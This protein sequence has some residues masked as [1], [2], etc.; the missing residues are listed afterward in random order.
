MAMSAKRFLVGLMLLVA[1]SINAFAATTVIVKIKNNGNIN[2]IAASLGGTILDSMDD[3]A[4]YLLSVPSMP[5]T[6]PPGCASI[7]ANTA[8]VLPRFKG[9]VF[10]ASNNV[11]T[12][13]WYASQPAFRLIHAASAQA[14]STGRGVI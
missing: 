4:T 2:S 8:L 13:P 10:T 12:L 1:L 11:G 6:L 7:T 3:G 5:S 14:K 9:S